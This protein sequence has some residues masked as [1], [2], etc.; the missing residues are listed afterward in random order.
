MKQQLECRPW[1][2]P[3][4]VLAAYVDEVGAA[5]VARTLATA[6]LD[7]LPGEIGFEFFL[8]GER[9]AWGS[10]LPNASP[11]MMVTRICVWPGA[12]GR[13]VRTMVKD[14]LAHQAFVELGATHLTPKIALANGPQLLR[15]L[16]AAAAGSIWRFSHV[17]LYPPPIV[18]FVVFREDYLARRHLE[19]L[20]E[21]FN[22]PP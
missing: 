12:R 22:E 20:Y 18:H 11:T 7:A 21:R 16:R 15:V 6:R 14:H 4:A 17:T 5:E 9:V 13:G 3:A 8:E 19:D 1:R 2:D 10:L